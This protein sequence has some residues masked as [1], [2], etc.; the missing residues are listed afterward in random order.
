MCEARYNPIESLPYSHR[1]E[2]PLPPCSLVFPTLFPF[3]PYPIC[4]FALRRFPQQH[5]R[6]A[7]I[8][9]ANAHILIEVTH[10]KL[11][12]KFV[13][14]G[15]VADGT[16]RE[17]LELDLDLVLGERGNVRPDGV[18]DTEDLFGIDGTAVFHIDELFWWCVCLEDLRSGLS[19]D[20]VARRPIWTRS[21][22][23]CMLQTKGNRELV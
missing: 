13:A 12:P 20:A 8:P 3:F 5:K 17:F 18:S 9:A 4:V 22:D 16:D 19:R 10:G 11:S 14:V 6:V 1:M 2:I 7:K 21:K 23:V 15:F